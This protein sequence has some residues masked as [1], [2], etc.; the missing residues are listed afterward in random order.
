ML[1]RSDR[2]PRNRSSRFPAGIRRSSSCAA[3]SRAFNLRCAARHTTRGIRLE[4]RVLRSRNRSAVVSSANDCI[5]APHPIHDTRYT[6]TVYTSTGRRAWR[7]V[8][9]A[10]TRRASLTGV[11]RCGVVYSSDLRLGR[12]GNS[13]HLTACHAVVTLRMVRDDTTQRCHRLG[14]DRRPRHRLAGSRSGWRIPSIGSDL[15]GDAVKPRPATDCRQNPPPALAAIQTHYC[16]DHRHAWRCNAD[17]D[18]DLQKKEARM[19]LKEPY[20]RAA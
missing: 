12:M 17:A 15:A 6:G 8:D 13:S 9:A 7:R 18:V 1:C 4:S 2:A 3:T 11:E 10:I 19:I 5:N 14:Q 16:S 20:A